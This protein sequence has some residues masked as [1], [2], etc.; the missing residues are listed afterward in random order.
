MQV[1]AKVSVRRLKDFALKLPPDHPLRAVLLVENDEMGSEE[2]L[3][4]MVT[5]LRLLS[6]KQEQVTIDDE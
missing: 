4:K 6:T 3:C 2:V 5:W 1:E